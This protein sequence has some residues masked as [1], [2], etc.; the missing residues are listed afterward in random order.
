MFPFKMDFLLCCYPDGIL[1][2]ISFLMSY[3][4][5]KHYIY[6][7]FLLYGSSAF[8]N[9]LVVAL[10]SE[11]HIYPVLYGLPGGVIKRSLME[12]PSYKHHIYMAYLVYG[13]SDDT[14]VRIGLLKPSY[15]HHIDM[16]FLLYGSSD[17]MIKQ[18]LFQ[19]C[20]Y[21][22]IYSAFALYGSI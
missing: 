11:Y 13:S 4:I 22:H 20:H 12:I 17:G 7:A 15:K 14:T 18:I 6:M 16:T 1:K 19:M 5:M 21:K 3:Y 10:L 8:R 9:K 2:C